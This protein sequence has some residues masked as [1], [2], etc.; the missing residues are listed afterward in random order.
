[1]RRP[2]RA[3][4]RRDSETQN[5][6]GQCSAGDAAVAQGLHSNLLL[7]L[8]SCN[9]QPVTSDCGK[10]SAIPVEDQVRDQA[11]PAG[12]MRGAEPGTRVAVEVLVE[13]D[14]VAPGRVLLR[15]PA[16]AE[17]RPAA[18]LVAQEQLHEPARELVGDLAE[19]HQ[20]PG[21]G[22]ALDLE[23]RAEIALVD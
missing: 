2:G 19:R 4:A 6:C 5:G 10:Q 3:G 13:E 15:E 1:P 12:L 7:A 23:L 9:V 16:V 11:G 21:S 18:V 17:H 22:R 8:S 14:Q 20:L